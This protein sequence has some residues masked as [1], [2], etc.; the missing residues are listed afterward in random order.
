MIIYIARNLND[1]LSYVGKTGKPL[2]E[3][4]K[5]HL[6]DARNGSRKY[7]HNA[8]RKYG[9]SAFSLEIICQ[10]PTPKGGGLKSKD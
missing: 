8:I 7:F 5:Q 6:Q 1:G 4:W 3:R 10:Y 9:E 2:L